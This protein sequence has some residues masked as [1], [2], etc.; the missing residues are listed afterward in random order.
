[1]IV[2]RISPATSP[3]VV[4]VGIVTAC[5]SVPDI[6]FGEEDAN[7]TT[8]GTVVPDNSRNAVNGCITWDAAADDLLQ[9][10]MPAMDLHTFRL[11]KG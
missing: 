8:D 9:V 4:A 11:R 3:V 6:T 2:R 5:R 10:T 7:A 1:M